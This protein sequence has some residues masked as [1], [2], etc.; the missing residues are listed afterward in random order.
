MGLFVFAPGQ[1]QV[2]IR[3]VA[4]L[5][6]SRL[7]WDQEIVSSNLT[8]P[9][10]RC[11]PVASRRSYSRIFTNAWRDPALPKASGGAAG[12]AL[13]FTCYVLY[14]FIEFFEIIL[15]GP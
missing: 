3:G 13:A 8:A 11:G 4:K 9:T 5:G 7:V 6:L 12:Y 1:R 2:E 15:V 14:G 10:S